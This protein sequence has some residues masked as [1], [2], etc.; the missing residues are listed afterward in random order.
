MTSILQRFLTES[1][2]FAIFVVFWVGAIASLGSC[3]LVRM[4]IVLG[5]VAGTSDSRRR[6]FL[7]TLFFVLGSILSYMILG[8]LFGVIGNFA[9][10]LVRISKYVFWTL[11]ILLF[12]IGLFI[13]GLVKLGVLSSH[14]HAKGRLKKVSFLGAFL[15]GTVFTFIEMPACPCYCGALLLVI[16]GIVIPKG[17]ILYSTMI[18][19]SF[20]IGQCVP[21]LAVGSS[22]SLVKY[23]T[24]KIARFDSYIRLVAGNVLMVLGIYF[25]VTA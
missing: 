10:R 13:S 25:L 6:S 20:A 7:L 16:A 15:L 17:S 14:H 5:Y 8:T 22:A 2:F 4:P 24:P 21:L 12:V 23:L 9:L 18:F 1:P 3:T 19:L 11:G